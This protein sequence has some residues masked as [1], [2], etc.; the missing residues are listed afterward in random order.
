MELVDTMS[1]RRV[2]IACIQETKWVGE[3]SKEI[4][5]TGP[6][7]WYTGKERNRNGVGILF[8]KTFKDAV[9]AESFGR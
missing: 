9:V 7:L 5:N 4:G 2:H 1:R 3:K 6:R 8:D